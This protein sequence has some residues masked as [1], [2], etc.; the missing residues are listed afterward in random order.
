M[1][2][3]PL[4]LHQ[5]GQTEL[6]RASLFR[7]YGAYLHERFPLVANALLIISFYS[8]NQ[9]LAQ[10]LDQAGRP[11]H[12][13]L[14]S[15]LGAITLL[16]FFLHIR[17]FDDHKD[18]V[19]DCRYFPDRVLQR[20][21]VT[22]TH[23]KW[24]LAAILIVECT[25]AAVC[26]IATWLAWLGALAFSLLML[27]EFFLGAWLR[28]RFLLYATVHMLIIP[29]LTAV[30]WSFATGRFFWTA[31]PLY[32]L[33]SAAGYLLAFN[34]EVSR[35][36]RIPKDEIQGVDSYSA[37]LGTYRAAW[38]AQALRFVSTVLVAIVAYQLDL[39]FLF[40]GILLVLLLVCSIGLVQHL[41]FTSSKSA[42]LLEVYA[43]VY[44]LAFDLALATEL[45]LRYGIEVSVG[46]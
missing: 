18:F 3:N 39:S 24:L 12:Y 6:H 27:R 4:Q 46:K 17:I 1:S 33:Y 2:A 8:S 22:L 9:F 29:V 40:Y 10:A 42:K 7:R 26:G 21:I 35:K 15:Y 14:R 31:P 44:I 19:S 30:I 34:W 43:G 11:V 28:E 36:I 38:L 20:G 23:L 16:C 13:D 32:W 5:S 25:A 45:G 41:V 37:R